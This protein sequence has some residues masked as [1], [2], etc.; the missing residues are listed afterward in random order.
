[1][2]SRTFSKIDVELGTSEPLYPTMTTESLDLRWSFIRKIYSI[3]SIQLLLTVVVGA[4]VVFYDHPIVTFLTKTRG[5]FACDILI[6]ISPFIIICLLA[7]YHRRHPVNYVL[8][9]IFTIAVAFSLGLSCALSTSGMVILEAAIL[10]AVMVVSLTLYT[11]WAAKKGHDI[12]YFW[13]P[14]PTLFG[15][16]MVL[17]VFSIIQ[18]FFP[19]GEIS[20]MIY[21]GVSAII[22]CGYIVYDTDNLIKR[23]TYDEYIWA[24]VALYLDVI[25]LF[26]AL[27]RI[28]RASRRR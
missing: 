18:I 25:N 16:L 17:S 14:S 2:W 1:M 13:G 10:T 4:W 19:M 27:L 23:Y 26:L 21:A 15:S 28:L 7:C 20:V 9:G 24:A 11:F 12:N 22:F 8:L 5:G 6:F 3:V